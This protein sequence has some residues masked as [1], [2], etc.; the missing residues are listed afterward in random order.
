MYR[1]LP[2]TG[3]LI[4]SLLMMTTITLAG[5]KFS[6]VK[7][8]KGNSIRLDRQTGSVSYCRKIG[9]GM[10]CT[11]AADDRAALLSEN[12]QLSNRVDELE[13]RIT[14]LEQASTL[15]KQESKPAE[16]KTLPNKD[17]SDSPQDSRLGRAK[18]VTENVLRRFIE[19]AKN[20][21]S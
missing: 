11:M 1:V 14:L 13:N 4:L 20:I 10:V 21:G 9:S 2:F 3:T 6:L 16:N 12:A 19:V 7:D 17:S 15:D 18:K 5:E 8:N